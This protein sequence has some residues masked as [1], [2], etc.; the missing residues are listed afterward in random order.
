MTEGSFPGGPAFQGSRPHPEPGVTRRGCPPVCVGV[1]CCHQQRE[2]LAE[3]GVDGLA[4]FLPPRSLTAA[5]H[6]RR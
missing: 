2:F 4:V 3:Q 6:Q 1:P 5:V